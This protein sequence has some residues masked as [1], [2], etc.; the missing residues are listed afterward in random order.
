MFWSIYAI[1]RELV[2]PKIYD[3]V[4]PWWFNHCVHTN[5]AIV[6][7]IETLLT[8]RR[9]PTSKSWELKLTSVVAFGYAIVYVYSLITSSSSSSTALSSSSS[10]PSSSS[11]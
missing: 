7:L 11:A 10:S 4:V 1:D 6:V 8:P 9:Y 2:F 3:V 5:V